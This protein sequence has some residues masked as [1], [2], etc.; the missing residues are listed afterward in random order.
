MFKYT[1]SRLTVLSGYQSNY[2][3]CVRIRTQA[4]PTTKTMLFD[5]ILDGWKFS[6]HCSMWNMGW[7]FRAF[8]WDGG[9]IQSLRAQAGR[10]AGV[11][12]FTFSGLALPHQEGSSSVLQVQKEP[13]RVATSDLPKIPPAKVG[14][15]E[16]IREEKIS[17]E[18]TAARLEQTARNTSCRLHGRLDW[19]VCLKNIFCLCVY[20]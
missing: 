17:E 4:S 11:C 16:K 12:S 15:R 3:S 19:M 10:Q 8:L 7:T 2:F 13:L 9:L 18:L 20:T 5:W 6:L 14:H 1:V